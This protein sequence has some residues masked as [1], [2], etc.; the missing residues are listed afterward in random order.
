MNQI[1]IAFKSRTESMSF[2]DYLARG[3]V[4]ALLINTPRELSVG[5]GLSVSVDERYLNL[6]KIMLQKF[7][8]KS[9]YLGMFKQVKNG[10]RTI[11]IP[12]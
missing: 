1:I 8:H 7:P 5:C 6:L 2:S 9:T 3:G 4:S 12:I 11:T 10:V